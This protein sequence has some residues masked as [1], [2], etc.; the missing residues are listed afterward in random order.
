[1][2]NTIHK[3]GFRVDEAVQDA[4][5]DPSEIGFTFDST[6]HFFNE[7]NWFFSDNT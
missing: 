4:T 1:M 5:V 6:I 2:N 3:I 7:I